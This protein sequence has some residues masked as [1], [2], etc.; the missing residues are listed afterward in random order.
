MRTTLNCELMMDHY[1]AHPYWPER[2]E[3]IRIQR[4]SGMNR[5]RSDEKRAA[6]LKAQL[7]KAGLTME[8]YRALER[9]AAREWYREDSVKDTGRIVIPR[10]QLAGCMVE[11]V[12]R[13]PKNLRGPFDKDS[14]RS[15]VQLSDFVTDRT[16]KDG[17]FDRYVKLE[18]SNMRNHQVNPFIQ[19]FTATGTVS[20]PTD[21]KAEDLRRLL[22]Y[23][24]GEIGVGAS[25]KMGYGRGMVVSLQ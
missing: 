8:D 2:E 1:I 12:G 13:A 19:T 23:A 16:D 15:M 14:F 25:R 4:D 3:L 6:A 24:V 22:D 18:K 10:H 20:I 9:R 5:Q 17:V 21:V 7:D 11:A